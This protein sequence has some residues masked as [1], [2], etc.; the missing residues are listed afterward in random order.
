VTS[1]LGPA[2]IRDLAARLGGAAD[3]ALGQNFVKR[4]LAG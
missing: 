3:Q 2:V 1:L 4:I